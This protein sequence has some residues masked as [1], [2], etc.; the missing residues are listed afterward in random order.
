MKGTEK[1]QKKYFHQQSPGCPG[2]P[3]SLS[4][5]SYPRPAIYQQ[6]KRPLRLAKS[7]RAR[8]RFL[9]VQ[10]AAGIYLRCP[11]LAD[12]PF[13]VGLA[14]LLSFSDSLQDSSLLPSAFPISCPLS[15][16]GSKMMQPIFWGTELWVE[17]M[18]EIC[19]KHRLK[20]IK[21][22][23]QICQNML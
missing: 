15:L 4:D 22:W 12:R 19:A 3:L 16:W 1:S 14:Q 23:A 10:S 2:C 7:V 21:K 8:A 11:P 6:A 13:S 17:N 5:P 20:L 18:L 9:W